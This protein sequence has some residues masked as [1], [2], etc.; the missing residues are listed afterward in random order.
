MLE[1]TGFLRSYGNVFHQLNFLAG[2]SPAWLYAAS[3]PL[4]E[5]MLL[6]FTKAGK[7]A[8]ITT[9]I[10]VVLHSLVDFGLQIPRMRME[11]IR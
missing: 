8:G 10:M 5:E 11:N 4:Q 1:C 2:L 7:C 9:I 6:Q 3:L